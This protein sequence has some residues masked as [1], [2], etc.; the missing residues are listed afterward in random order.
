VGTPIA[1]VKGAFDWG[2]SLLAGGT[3]GI[4]MDPAKFTFDATAAPSCANDYVAFNTSLAGVSP[5]M[6]A[7]QG[8]NLF[9]LTGTPVGAFTITHGAASLVLTAAP[10]N[11]GTDFLVVDNAFG[12]NTSNAASLA[13][14]ITV[15]GGGPIGVTAASVGP[16]VNLTAL[17]NGVEGNNITVSS[18][19]TNFTVGGAFFNGVGRGNIVAFNNLYA[20]QG[21]VAGFCLQN[22]PSVYWSYYTGAGSAVTSIVLSLDGSKVAFVENVAGIATLRILQWKAGEG[23]GTGYPV[24]VDQDISGANWSTCTLGNS[25]IA[26]IAFSGAAADTKSSPFYV[27]GNNA[28]ILYVGDDT[29]SVHKFTGVFNG[30]PAEVTTAPW[31]IAVNAGAI[32][33]SPIFDSISG[34]IFVGDSTGLLSY[35]REVGSTVGTACTLPCLGTPSIHVGG[36]GGSIDDAPI[37]DVTNGTVFAVNGTDAGNDGTILQASTALIGA[38]SFSLGGGL[39][40]GSPIYSGAFDNTYFMSSPGAIAGHMYIC[41]KEPGVSNRPAIYQLNFTLAG[42][43]NGATPLVGLANNDGGACSPVTEFF[44]PNGGGAGV[45]TDWIFFSIGNFAANANPIPAGSAC[46]TNNAGCVISVD[47]TDPLAVWPPLSVT[48]TAPVPARNAGSTS[49]IVVDNQADTTVGVFPQASSLYFTLGANSTGA[50]PGVPSCDTTPGVGC[51]VKLTQAGL[52]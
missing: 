27:Y 28:D 13:A 21:S 46:G 24:A 7:I 29:G 9:G 39:S 34:N 52:N 41:G 35:I 30:T 10:D 32:L 6:A 45:A 17:N 49:G 4:G 50:G 36:A 1:S 3:I 2:E 37:V 14:R 43:L 42:V 26:S 15:F 19:L 16:A 44:N 51:A 12:G 5:T 23:A 31:P 38:V 11:I 48:N 25:C 40:V 33:T 8:G 47:V 18:S 22:G 20:T